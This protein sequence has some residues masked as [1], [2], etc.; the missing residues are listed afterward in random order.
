VA[1][2]EVEQALSAHE[3]VAE[4]AVTGAPDAERGQTVM[5]WVVLT[6]DTEPDD[7]LRA[8]LQRFVKDRLAPYKYP[9]RIV[10]MKQLPRDPLGK[11]VMKTLAGWANSGEVPVDAHVR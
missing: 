1:P 5:A 7:A 9:R 8:E 11:I 4:V 3:A 10:F 2:V 6:P